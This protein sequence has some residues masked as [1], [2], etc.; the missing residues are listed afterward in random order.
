[1]LITKHEDGWVAQGLEI[2]YAIDGSS[3]EDVKKRFEQGLTL[4]VKA[5]LRVHRN[6]TRLLSNI[7]PPAIWAKFFAAVPP[8]V[9]HKSN[10]I[11]VRTLPRQRQPVL[12]FDRIIF[13]QAE[14][15]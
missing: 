6:I 4:T 12:P 9:R 10:L 2:D 7:A 15:A 11:T 5:N 14:A 8:D 1:V 13:A 3:V